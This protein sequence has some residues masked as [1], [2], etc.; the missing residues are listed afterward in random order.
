MELRIEERFSVDAPVAAVWDH[1]VDPGRV[2]AC[3]PGGELEKVLDERTFHGTVRVRIA[4]VTL[5]FRGRVRLEEVDAAARRVRIVGEAREGLGSSVRLGLASVIVPRAGGGAE[6]TAWASAVVQG[7]IVPLWRGPLE[8]LA[9]ELF[10]DFSTCVASAVEAER[11]A[12]AAGR[13]LPR[14]VGP[15]PPLLLV[16]LVF[17]ALRAWVRARRR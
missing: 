9:H 16:P 10:R 14:V 4:G 3:V 5:A 17:R 13:P 2:V 8:L 1:L 15:R 11:V 12:A 7:R 6:V